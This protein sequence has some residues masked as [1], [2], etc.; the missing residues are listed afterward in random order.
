MFPLVVLLSASCVSSG[1]DDDGTSDDDEE[2]EDARKTAVN[3]KLPESSSSSHCRGFRIIYFCPLQCNSFVIA[4]IIYII[5]NKNK[6]II[7]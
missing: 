1:D 7:N 2:E 5:I 4:T 3:V 6:L